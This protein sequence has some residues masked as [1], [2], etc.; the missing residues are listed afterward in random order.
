M[1]LLQDPSCMLVATPT[2]GVCELHQWRGGGGAGGVLGRQPRGALHQPGHCDPS[3][4]HGAK[5][6]H[7]N[8]IAASAA[9]V[10]A[11]S[12]AA[13]VA[14]ATRPRHSPAVSSWQ[15]FDVVWQSVG[16]L[17]CQRN[18]SLR[19]LHPGE[20][21]CRLRLCTLLLI[22]L[23]LT[24]ARSTLPA[25]THVLLLQSW[26]IWSDTAYNVQGE[27]GAYY[28]LTLVCSNDAPVQVRRSLKALHFPALLDLHC[29]VPCSRTTH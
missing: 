26:N 9:A 15:L 1:Q 18:L 24:R 12:A 28:G 27:T 21:P 29:P 17:E 20:I 7:H 22:A 5:L 16:V 10:A 14:T 6:R 11:A 3:V 23:R 4:L 8:T 25:N 19:H 2:A 13:V